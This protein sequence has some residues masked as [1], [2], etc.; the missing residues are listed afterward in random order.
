MK[1]LILA[2]GSPRRRELLRLAGF[3]FTVQTAEADEGTV[4]YPDGRPDLYVE[5]LARLKNDAVAASLSGQDVVILSADTVVIAPP[6]AGRLL[7]LGKPASEEEARRM[8]SDLSGRTHRVLTGV[9]IRDVPS[10]RTDLFHTVTEVTFRSLSDREIDVYCKSGE[11][12]DKAGAYGIQGKA[13]TFVESLSGDYFNVVGLPLCRVAVGL[14]A[15]GILP[16]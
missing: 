11:P 7:P 9:M 16:L 10:G 2:S 1:R 5:S 8:L 12:L 6:E 4:S 14:S 13:C 15:F 3:D